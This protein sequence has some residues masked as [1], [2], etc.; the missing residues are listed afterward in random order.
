MLTLS[1]L[2]TLFG[3]NT[4]LNGYGPYVLVGL[5]LVVFIESGVLFPFLPCDSLLVAVAALK[6][7]LGLYAWE[8]IATA[9]VAAI[10]GDQV[11]FYL[12]RRFGR[13]L[14]S[15]NARILRTDRLQAAEDFFRR[16][17]PFALVLGRFVPIVRTFVPFAAGTARLSYPR[18][19]GWNVAGAV[20]WVVLM[21]S[22]G[23]FFGD[24][25]G[26]AH[27][28]D[29]VIIAVSAISILPVLVGVAK[30]WRREKAYQ[31]SRVS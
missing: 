18:F 9:I 29:F 15:D 14:F 28:I 6:D 19:V 23:V 11:G 8:I 27:S 12:G 3:T 10:L 7:S 13:K 16:R 25:S 21:V 20:F 1:L 31:P 2:G 26:L 5:G 17:G 4:V 22:V 30:K 24:I